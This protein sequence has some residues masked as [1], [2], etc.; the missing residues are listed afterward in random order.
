MVAEDFVLFREGLARLLT[1]AGLEVVAQISDGDAL[2]AAVAADPPD[3]VIV[4]VRLPPTQ[5]TE[6][7]RA[8]LDI[9]ADHPQVGVLVLSQHI[10]TEYAV[11]LLSSAKG[12]VGY[13]LKEHVTDV[14][15]LAD[16]VTRVAAGGSVIDPEVVARLLGRRRNRSNLDDLSSR[17][18]EVLALMAEGRS[19]SA[20]GS[21]L[22]ITPSTVEAHIRSIFSKLELEDAPDDNRRVLS[23]VAFLRR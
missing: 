1:D 22:F 8:A 6:G 3:A 13:L 15:T 18:L 7:L 5:T 11:E 10:E 16:A 20:I 9:R 14:A 4:D 17:E 2:R 23:V 12:G 21:R 19:N